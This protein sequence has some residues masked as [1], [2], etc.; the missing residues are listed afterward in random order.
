MK[1]IE[2]LKETWFD[3]GWLFRGFCILIVVGM[4]FSIGRAAFAVETGAY[5]D[6]ERPGHGIQILCNSNDQ[7]VVYWF[8]YRFGHTLWM[9]SDPLCDR[10]EVCNTAF[11]TPSGDWNAQSGIELGDPMATAEIL[12]EGRNL[13]IE[14]EAIDLLGEFCNTGSGGLI[15][16]ECIGIITMRQ[17]AR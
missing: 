1:L 6:P 2:W 8:N 13:V 3:A 17:F 10:G 14:Y 16:R 15:L 4:L 5:S 11:F 9:I 12:V 7:C